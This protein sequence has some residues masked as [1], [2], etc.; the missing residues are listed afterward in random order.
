M[1]VSKAMPDPCQDD[2]EAYSPSSQ[3]MSSSLVKKIRRWRILLG[4]SLCMN[5]PSLS[6]S[7]LNLIVQRFIHS[8]IFLRICEDRGIEN[9]DRLLKLS[10]QRDTSKCLFEYF[11]TASQNYQ[12]HSLHLLEGLPIDEITVDDLLTGRI[13]RD[14][15]PTGDASPF[16]ILHDDFLGQI[17]EH[18]LAQPISR[19]DTELRSQRK[20]NNGVFYT[21][22]YI[23][24][25]MTNGTLKPFLKDKTPQE[26]GGFTR[27]WKLSHCHHPLSIL[28]PSCGSGNF[29]LTTYQR[30]LDWHLA[31]YCTAG[32]K[33]YPNKLRRRKDNQLQLSLNEKLRILKSNIFGLDLDQQAIE[34]AKSVLIL[35]AVKDENR[36]SMSELM[37]DSQEPYF[38]SLGDNIRCGNALVGAGFNEKTEEFNS[39]V[40]HRIK[41]FDWGENFPRVKAHGGFD[42]VIGN[43]PYR[44]ERDYKD[45]LSEIAQYHFGKKYSAPRMDLW[46]YFVHR[47]LEQLHESGSLSFIVNSYWLDSS[48]ARKLIDSIEKEAH[49]E[50]VFLLGKLK[51]FKN[52]SGHHM[53]FRITKGS[54]EKLITI[55][56]G[57][58]Y[59]TCN[60][61]EV[62]QGR[63]EVQEYTKTK[64]QVFRNGKI[65][66]NSSSSI[67]D[68]LDERTQLGSYGITRQ[69]IAENPASINH[70]INRKL[71]ES[72]CVGEGVFAL[73]PSE[74]LALN[75]SEEEQSLIRSYH[76]LSDIGRYYVA[77]EASLSL[78]YSTPETCPDI[79]LFPKLRNHLERFRKIMNE[80]RETQ[81]GSRAWWHL[82]WPRDEAIWKSPKI[83][84]VQM[85]TRPQFAMAIEPTYVS[86]SVNAFLPNDSSK[87]NLLFLTAILNSRLLWYWF[88]NRG[89]KRGIGLEINGKTLSQAPI[90]FPE[91]KS[92]KHSHLREDIVLIAEQRIKLEKHVKTIGDTP[93]IQED[94]Q[95]LEQQLDALVYQLYGLTTEEMRIVDSLTQNSTSTRSSKDKRGSGFA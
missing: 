3:T 23:T 65:D 78:I 48:G 88:I 19:K 57:R 73:T 16:Q 53:I 50:E 15:Y 68:K 75:L 69:G 10:H 87:E 81:R 63:L 24:E 55:K 42:V 67:L 40:Q 76:H 59:P 93:A 12:I 11:R 1:S 89:K 54:K 37:H 85:G 56:D 33:H 70:S 62:V 20:R 38:P 29:L 94:L 4:E 71:N 49:L 6:D 14:L 30:L 7:A 51:V 72:W 21:P 26:I 46:Y 25:Y 79:S 82:H 74:L 27:D 44:R 58:S 13:I 17:Y 41:P 43:P 77:S 45:L 80:R 5:N 84:S 22:S 64:R 86:F 39:E 52:V 61:E 92:S 83:L 66:L 34:V 32:V 31:F 28:D 47:G 60:P 36:D 35:K 90:A 8:V 9:T 2:K 95:S 18:F 91:N